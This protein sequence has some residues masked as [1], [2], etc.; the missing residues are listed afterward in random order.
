MTQ[1]PKDDPEHIPVEK[2]L[3]GDFSSP[4]EVLGDHALTRD[5]K[6][7]ILRVWLNDLSSQP[8]S[9]ETRGVRDSVRAA[10][11]DLERETQ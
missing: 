6:R 3:S 4:M 10:L 1:D 11:A 5:Q 7:Q 9:G 2:R 8:E